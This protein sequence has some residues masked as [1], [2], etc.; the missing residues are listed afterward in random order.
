MNYALLFTAYGTAGIIG[1]ILAGSVFD[2]TGSYAWAF[3][4]SGAAC[5]VAAGIALRLAPPHRAGPVTGC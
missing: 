4:P 3:I 1:P 5:L 2:M